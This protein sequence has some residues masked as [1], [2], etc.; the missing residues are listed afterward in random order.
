MKLSNDRGYALIGAIA[1]TAVLTIV[2]LGFVNVVMN[3]VENEKVYHN[4]DRSF[5]SAE[6]GLMLGAKWIEDPV[7]WSSFETMVEGASNDNVFPDLL[8]N[9]YVV[10]VDIVKLDTGLIILSTAMSLSDLGY[11][12]MLS[13]EGREDDGLPANLDAFDYAIICD[14]VFNFGGCGSITSEDASGSALLHSNSD[15]TVCGS[16]N[17]DL[18]ITS[19]TYVNL[20]NKLTVEGSVT[21][22]DISMH[23]KAVVTEGST[24][25]SVDEITIPDIDLSPWYNVAAANNE[26]YTGDYSTSM[27]YTPDGGVLW[28]YGNVRLEGGPG[29]TFNGMIIATGNIEILGQVN[30]IT[31]ENGFAI[32]SEGGDILNSSSGKIQGLIY[33]KDGDY[34]QD[35][36]GAVEGQIIVNGSITKKGCSDVIVYKKY[37]PVDPNNNGNI[38]GCL[39]AGTWKEANVIP[40]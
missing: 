33:T 28:V 21:A 27:S 12:K 34:T 29:T 9:D 22:P 24:V 1:I 11:N 39:V 7:N 23:K 14:G 17:G 8:I 13:Q 5:F 26:V 32:A 38:G 31:P 15:I 20:E 18:D 36:N 3:E 16:A 6:S 35:A 4:N 10:Q 2:V 25:D 40:E 30:V 19:S 37:L